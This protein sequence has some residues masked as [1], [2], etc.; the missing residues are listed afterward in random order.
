MN[1]KFRLLKSGL[2]LKCECKMRVGT[3]QWMN[4]TIEY[5]KRKFGIYYIFLSFRAREW[6]DAQRNCHYFS[7]TKPFGNAHNNNVIR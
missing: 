3:L 7:K 1:L 4:T 6:Q 5:I 2:L